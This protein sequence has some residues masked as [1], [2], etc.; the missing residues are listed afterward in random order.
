[1]DIKKI[2]LLFNK[3]LLLET[4]E[5]KGCDLSEFML[6][7]IY[8][9]LRYTTKQ[10]R[11]DTKQK[12]MKILDLKNSREAKDEIRKDIKKIFDAQFKF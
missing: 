10:E 2:P 6:L 11:C 12:C 8:Q 4:F 9:A 7:N 5:I 1:M 3:K